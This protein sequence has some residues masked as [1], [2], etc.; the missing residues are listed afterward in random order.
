MG[1]LPW[2]KG[3]PSTTNC[4]NNC[5]FLA[6]TKNPKHGGPTEPESWSKDERMYSWQTDDSD[7]KDSL[8]IWRDIWTPICFKG[9]WKMDHLS[10]LNLTS[11]D[12]E[13]TILRDLH[14]KIM[15]DRNN[16]C[17]FTDYNEGMAF[18]TASELHRI[19]Y[20]HHQLQRN[21]KYTM[22]GL[23]IAGG[24]LV[25]NVIMELYKHLR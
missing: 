3:E 24:A 10:D 17:F 16:R 2:S 14:A 18:D 21:Y 9:I 20:D 25:A 23:C 12:E 4:C 22:I 11:N 8:F 7:G 6:K 13:I 5:H 19:R 15:L 1:D